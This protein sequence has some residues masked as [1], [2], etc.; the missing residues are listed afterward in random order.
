[1]DPASL[2]ELA[3]DI[4][5]N[6]LREPI[7][8]YEGKMLDGRNRL[9]A[10]QMAGVKPVFREVSSDE[11]DGSTLLYVIS[12]NL[13]RRHLTESQRAAVATDMEPLLKEE[14]KKRKAATQFHS[15][16]VPIDAD[17]KT[18]DL[19]GRSAEI[20]A[21]VMNVGRRSVNRAAKVKREDPELHEKVKRGEAT[22]NAAEKLVSARKEKAPTEENKG[23][24]ATVDREKDDRREAERL[25]RYRGELVLSMKEV[26]NA[27]KRLRDLDIGRL[28]GGIAK[29]IIKKWAKNAAD[30]AHILA[31]FAKA[32]TA[33]N[34]N[35]EANASTI[36]KPCPSATNLENEHE[37]SQ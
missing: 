21:R 8:L 10:C 14:A 31:E 4:K 16:S 15:R 2:K 25:D 37:T 30:S 35:T 13:R 22:L 24:S 7:V 26:T 18:K 23:D 19:P 3:E 9:K 5:V 12:K 20:A 27:C 11:I 36:T 6:G 33:D 28:R 17:R 1:M 34:S 29:R 32:L